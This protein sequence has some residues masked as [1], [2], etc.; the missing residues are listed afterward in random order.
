MVKEILPPPELKKIKVLLHSLRKFGA[1]SMTIIKC[2]SPSRLS[3]LPSFVFLTDPS[4]LS[5]THP[6]RS[7]WSR[8]F[9][10]VGPTVRLAWHSLWKHLYHLPITTKW[11]IHLLCFFLMNKI[12]TSQMHSMRLH[13][14]TTTLLSHFYPSVPTSS[15]HS[16]LLSLLK[17][18]ATG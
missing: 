1:Y 16:M 2:I 5:L 6:L 12:Y 3:V 7:Q 15:S 4:P 8:R 17:P 18:S 11:L 9:S 10:M 14:K 13:S